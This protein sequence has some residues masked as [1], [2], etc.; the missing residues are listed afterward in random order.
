[1]IQRTRARLRNGSE[2]PLLT[3]QT[4]IVG[5]GAAAL[6]CAEHLWELGV[7][8]IAI[9]TGHLSAGTSN[10]AGSDKHTYCKIGIFGDTPD[11]PLGF[12]RALTAGG[13]CHGDI[14]YV[15][16]LASAPEFFHLVR[17]GVPF[18][19]NRY[20]AYVGYKSDHDPRQRATSAGPRTSR[21]M[22]EQ[23]LARVRRHGTPILDQ[24]EVIA[25]LVAG[26]GETRRVIGAMAIDLARVGSAS[27]GLVLF[28]AENVVMATGG[29]GELYADSVYPPGQIG[30][31]GLALEVGAIASNLAESQ[32]GLAS[33]GFRWNL[34]GAYQQVIPA[35]FS[36][37]PDGGDPRW[38]LNDYYPTISQQATSIFL[39]GY[40]WPF[41]AARVQGYGSSLIDLAVY[42]ERQGRFTR[43]SS[44]AEG[45]GGRTSSSMTRATFGSRPSAVASYGTAA[46]TCRC[47]GRSWRPRSGTTGACSSAR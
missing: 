13:M 15:E 2:V 47:G 29:P 35:Y 12:V 30:N 32:Y 33:L 23:S 18:P 31:H 27:F 11:S 34:S 36:V 40:Q 28:N 20:G 4:L 42:N 7:R 16:A 19:H 37:A 17:N 9:A 25:L 3:M 26:S 6:N 8:D 5:S 39:K 45:A 22:F 14:A 41:D 46:R 43:L 10:N 44:A 24:H 38:F 21:F 1:M